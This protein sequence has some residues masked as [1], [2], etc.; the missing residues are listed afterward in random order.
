MFWIHLNQKNP[1][2]RRKRI[3]F[4]PCAIDL[5]VNSKVEPSVTG[6]DETKDVYYRF[7]GKTKSGQSFAVQIMK[8]KKSNRY[9]MSCFPVKEIKKEKVR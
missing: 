4:V 6:L 5:I 2:E 7:F 8:D 1:S 9:F 3:A